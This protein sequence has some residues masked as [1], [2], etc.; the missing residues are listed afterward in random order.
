MQ[1]VTEVFSLANKCARAAEGH[2][3]HTPPNTEVGKV[4][5]TEAGATTQEG[6]GNKNKNKKKKKAS[7]NDHPLAGAPTAAVAA[8]T[9]GGGVT[10]EATTNTPVKHPVATTK[11]PGAQLHAPQR[12]RVPGNQEACGTVLQATEAAAA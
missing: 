4:G 1:D 6:G 7:G 5:K 2:A 11:V 9:A 3:W 10:H 8:A 12:Q